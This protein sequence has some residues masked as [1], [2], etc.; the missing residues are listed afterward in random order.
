MPVEKYYIP[1]IEEFHVGFEVE[2]MSSK[3]NDWVNYTITVD[4]CLGTWDIFLTK[5]R[6][7][8]LD[9]EDIESLGWKHTGHSID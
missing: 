1:E 2:T 3:T 8:Y 5:T 7:K 9:R 6:I 4:D